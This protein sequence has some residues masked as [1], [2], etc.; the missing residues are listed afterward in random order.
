MKRFRMSGF[1]LALAVVFV[2]GIS[3]AASAAI[4]AQWDYQDGNANG[5]IVDVGSGTQSVGTTPVPR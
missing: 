1:C 2:L 4:I 5:I 3:G